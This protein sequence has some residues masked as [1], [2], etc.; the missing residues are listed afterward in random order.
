MNSAQVTDDNLVISPLNRNN[1]RPAP[2]VFKRA[3]SSTFSRISSFDRTSSLGSNNQFASFKRSL[4]SFSQGAAAALGVAGP[5]SSQIIRVAEDIVDDDDS[6]R[7]PRSPRSPSSRRSRASSTSGDPKSRSPSHIGNALGTSPMSRFKRSSSL[8]QAEELDPGERKLLALRSKS[9]DDLSA[10]PDGSPSRAEASV[11]GQESK[12]SLEKKS[13][14]EKRRLGRAQLLEQR[15]IKL[16]RQDSEPALFDEDNIHFAKDIQ[17]T[18]PAEPATGEMEKPKMS[19]GALNALA[20][21]RSSVMMTEDN[22]EPKETAKIEDETEEEK[23]MRKVLGLRKYDCSQHACSPLHE[24][25][26]FTELGTFC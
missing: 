18:A 24:S 9:Y 22:E 5:K 23:T 6:P 3:D 4:S 15:S 14:A 12:D 10:D 11:S 1:N 20:K 16:T 25:F 21:L 17:H 8:V 2:G 19:K 13:R 26:A 7:S